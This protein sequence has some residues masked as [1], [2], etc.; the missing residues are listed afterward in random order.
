M[1][2]SRLWYVEGNCALDD[3]STTTRVYQSMLFAMKAFLKGEKTGT[4]GTSG[5]VPAGAKWT[6]YSSSDS[7]ST[8]LVTDL[9]GS[10]FD[11]SKIVLG[12][13]GT[14]HSWWVGRCPTSLTA[15][16]IPFYFGWSTTSSIGVFDF[17]CSKTAPSGGT[18]SA[19]PTS[20]DEWKYQ[21]ACTIADVTAAAHRAHW[22][23]DANG[24]ST[25]DFSRAGIVHTSMSPLMGF[26]TP[27]A[28][29]LFPI[30]SYFSAQAAGRGAL[31][32]DQQVMSA[33]GHDGA[34]GFNMRSPDG[35]RRVEDGINAG[36]GIITPRNSTWLGRTTTNNGSGLL[37]ALSCPIWYY[38]NVLGGIRGFMPDW[39]V[40]NTSK[41]VGDF[42]PAGAPSE[43]VIVGNIA[44]PNGGATLLF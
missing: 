35:S 39:Y 13:G 22:V 33:S 14:P 44:K 38:D 28:G 17:F 19:R 23:V 41:A 11:A 4:N 42:L 25:I 1:A 36:T 18:I 9:I 12:N 34:A 20:V 15:L 43:R 30:C 40:V 10:T 37:D 5:S 24:N 2:L 6:H 16:G 32:D 7:V 8:S 3:V 31:R 26:A 21:S 27:V 29:D